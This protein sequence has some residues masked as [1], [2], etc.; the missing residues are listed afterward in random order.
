M[1]SYFQWACTVKNYLKISVLVWKCEILDGVSF[2]NFEIYIIKYHFIVKK[3][4]AQ[5]QREQL[6]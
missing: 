5:H 2:K 3:E 6:L 1:F 4:I